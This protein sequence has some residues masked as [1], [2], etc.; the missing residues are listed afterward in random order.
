MRKAIR[1]HG[2]GILALAAWLLMNPPL[3]PTGGRVLSGKPVPE[4]TPLSFYDSVARCEAAREDDY[5]L[6]IA[7]VHSA[8]P[9]LTDVLRDPLVQQALFA[10]CVPADQVYPL[11]NAGTRGAATFDLTSPSGVSDNA[12]P[13][14]FRFTTPA[15]PSPPASPGGSTQ[16]ARPTPGTGILNSSRP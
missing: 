15:S 3:A 14:A 5:S 2:C 8:H 4:W 11:E 10:Q 13:P 16:G 6:V 1:A 12:G 9:N 7:N